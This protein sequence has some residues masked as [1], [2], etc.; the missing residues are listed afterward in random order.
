MSLMRGKLW[1]TLA[2]A[3]AVG[4][5]LAAPA[6]AA[7]PNYILV[8]GRGLSHPVLLSDWQDNLKLLLA[9]ANAPRAPGPTVAGLST[10]PRFDAAP[11]PSR[12]CST[13]CTRESSKFL[14]SAPTRRL[15]ISACSPGRAFAKTP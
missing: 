10:R 3:T 13:W 14:G 9:V 15:V 8:S 2:A 5:V 1:S 6:Q 4:F 12:S 11:A 7:A